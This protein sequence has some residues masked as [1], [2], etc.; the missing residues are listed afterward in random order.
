M[1]ADAG[2]ASLCG[3]MQVSAGGYHPCGLRQDGTV[4]CWG[5]MCIPGFTECAPKMCGNGVLD[6]NKEYD[7]GNRQGGDCCSSACLDEAG[8]CD[9]GDVRNGVEACD[10][11]NGCQTGTAPDFAS[12]AGFLTDAFQ[13]LEVCGGKR[14]SR[15]IR[16]V[17][18]LVAAAQRKLAKATKATRGK[19]Q[20]KLA[21]IAARKLKQANRKA[22]KLE[23]KLS[24]DCYTAVISQVEVAKD[25]VSCMK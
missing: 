11:T 14:D 24:A 13:A 2:T 17:T 1:F 20:R 8:S 25:Q 9:D 10:K 16:K 7:G 12:V 23:G 19:R 22:G 5:S 15:R 21:R 18:K 6:P 4:E 3:F